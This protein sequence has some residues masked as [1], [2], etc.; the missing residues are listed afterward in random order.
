MPDQ[1]YRPVDIDYARRL[2][3]NP[4]ALPAPPPKPAMFDFG[5]AESPARR[6][7]ESIMPLRY[8]DRLP[9]DMN[10]YTADA[11]VRQSDPTRPVGS[12]PARPEAPDLGPKPYSSM[13]PWAA[14][15][16]VPRPQPHRVEEQSEASSIIDNILSPKPPEPLEATPINA[17]GSLVGPEPEPPVHPLMELLAGRPRREDHPGNKWLAAL[18]G[19]ATGAHQGPAAGA[20]AALSYLD[21][22][23]DQAYGDWSADLNEQLAVEQINQAQQ[24]A[25]LDFILGREEV[26]TDRLGIQQRDIDSLRDFTATENRT[27]SFDRN[28]QADYQS[29]LLGLAL[30]K[31]LGYLGSEDRRR[32]AL[33]NAVTGQAGRGPAPGA[34]QDFLGSLYAFPHM[35][36]SGVVSFDPDTQ[37]YLL[38]EMSPGFFGGY[39]EN[40]PLEHSATGQLDALMDKIYRQSRGTSPQDM[41]RILGF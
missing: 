12:L 9:I 16:L 20:S 29:D 35:R 38:N 28:T 36:D 30:Q 3:G 6:V 18:L 7:E 14:D 11:A 13:D 24:Q 41:M 23:Y 33:L 26:A 32:M 10:P 22:P 1:P 40:T 15:A 5:R 21:R 17:V 4:N 8:E 19:G 25:M 2:R 37:G 39:N 34:E 31:E 27:G